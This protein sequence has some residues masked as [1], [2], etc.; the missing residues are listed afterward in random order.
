[1]CRPHAFGF[2]GN[3]YPTHENLKRA[4]GCGDD[5]SIYSHN[6]ANR[7]WQTGEKLADYKGWDTL[8]KVLAILPIF[9]Q[10]IG[11]GRIV[12]TA[13]A[14]GPMDAN[15]VSH[16]VRGSL[17]FLNLAPLLHV[18][19]GILSLIPPNEEEVMKLNS[20]GNIYKSVI[21]FRPSDRV[22]SGG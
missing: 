20:F 17:E 15:K 13:I 14:D 4:A 8:V 2:I 22:L 3:N 5:I 11:I 10:V 21:K 12:L 6:T 7:Y 1:M 19:D 16:I 18:V 9:A